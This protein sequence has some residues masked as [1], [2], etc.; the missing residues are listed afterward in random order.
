[1]LATGHG[2]LVQTPA[3]EWYIV[4]LGI[5]PQNPQNASGTNQLGRETFLAPVVWTDDGWPVVNGG[6]PISLE[7]PGLYELARPKVWRDDFEGGHFADK[8][9]SS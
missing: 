9:V 5:R 6:K 3:G 7:M 2:D 1:M 4:F 8:G